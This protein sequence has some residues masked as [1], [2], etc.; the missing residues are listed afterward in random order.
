[1]LLVTLF[2]GIASQAA[3]V[4]PAELQVEGAF[5][6]P[7]S[8]IEFPTQQGD[9]TRSRILS[10]AE[11]PRLDHSVTYRLHH[12][13]TGL[14]TAT[15]Y[16]FPND[17]QTPD[18]LEVHFDSVLREVS[19]VG[20]GYEMVKKL[21]YTF[22]KDEVKHP[23]LVALFLF[24]GGVGRSEEPRLE[25]LLLMKEDSYWIKW[26]ITTIGAV[27]ETRTESDTQL[28]RILKLVQSFLPRK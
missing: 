4:R 1:M 13:V 3:P 24:R 9:W 26:R 21:S 11:A 12:N 16:I 6:E 20:R 23:S 17:S 15:V 5:K 19:T 27:P 7:L 14:T 28:D 22:D 8:G 10:Y 18:H 25:Y 2:L